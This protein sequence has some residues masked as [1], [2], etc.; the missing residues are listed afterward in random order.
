MVASGWVSKASSRSCS[1]SWLRVGQLG[2]PVAGAPR[3]GAGRPR[4]GRGPRQPGWRGPPAS[5]GRRRP[6]GAGHRARAKSPPRVQ[7]GPERPVWRFH[8]VDAHAPGLYRSAL[9]VSSRP[10][11]SDIRGSPSRSGSRTA[12]RQAALARIDVARAEEGRREGR[13]SR[14][15]S[16]GRAPSIPPAAPESRHEAQPAWHA[17]HSAG[18]ARPRRR[19]SRTYWLRCA[20]A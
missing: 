6:V 2:P 19:V 13:G 17:P 1:A 14:S 11:L 20:S 15:R 12:G 5:L 3:P 8:H 9:I 16:R 4:G 7:R 18:R 10:P